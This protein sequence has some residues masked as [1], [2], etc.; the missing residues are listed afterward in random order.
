MGFSRQTASPPLQSYRCDFEVRQPNQGDR[1]LLTT[2][3]RPRIQKNRLLELLTTGLVRVAMGN[4]IPMA[5]IQEP[6]KGHVAVTVQEGDL[7]ASKGQLAHSSVEGV[8]GRLNRHLKRDGAVA[9]AGNKM[10]GDRLK[11]FYNARPA[12][13]TTVNN[14]VDSCRFQGL[15]GTLG[16]AKPA[17]SIADHSK[18]HRFLMGH[19]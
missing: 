18:K 2:D 14:L 4:E 1:R 5:I 11:Q 7:S 16:G 13:V 19:A 6:L 8:P 3:H 15:D 12:H 9:I 10:S 17:M